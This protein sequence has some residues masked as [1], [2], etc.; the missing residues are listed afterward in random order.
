MSPN[1]QCHLLLQPPLPPPVSTSS[2]TA[3]SAPVP[4][5]YAPMTSSPP[6]PAGS[7]GAMCPCSLGTWV[8]AQGDTYQVVADVSQFEPPDIVVTT[9]NCHVAIQAEKVRHPGGGQHIPSPSLPPSM[10]QCGSC[11]TV[12]SSAGGELGMAPA[13]TGVTGSCP[14]V[15]GQVA[16]APLHL[17]CSGVTG[18]GSCHQWCNWELSS[19]RMG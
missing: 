11:P 5:H 10:E 18:N 12:P 19:L 17:S 4:G 9:S 3:P 13:G 2:P 14:L 6:M 8:R 15:M 1:H 7:P 16:S